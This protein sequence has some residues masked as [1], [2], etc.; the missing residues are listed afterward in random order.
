LL[1]FSKKHEVAMT[2][3][4]VFFLF[5]G[6]SLWGGFAQSPFS[7]EVDSLILR[8]MDQT[9][10]C[11]FD[12]AMAT[13]QRVI[14]R[15]P[16]H[17]VGYFYQAAV[18]QSRMMDYETDLWEGDFY[19]LIDKAIDTGKKQLKRGDDN[20]WTYFYLG[21][22][23]SYK[24]LYQAKA[25]SFISGFISAH[26]GMGYFEKAVEMD[27]T[28]YDAYLGLG[29]Y[30]YWAGRFYKYLKFLPWIK[31]E[32]EKGIGMV[33]LSV[34]KG[35]FSY[36]AGL[37]SLA[38]IEY[39]R[40]R[41]KEALILFKKGLGKYPGSRFFQWGVADSYFQLND[42]SIAALFYQ[43]LLFSILNDSPNN[44]YNEV[45]C[46]FKLALSHFALGYYQE[47]LKECDAILQ[48]GVEEKISIRLEKYRK[49]ARKY[50]KECL[51]R[52]EKKKGQEK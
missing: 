5:L 48:R 10:L 3:R 42:F 30:K 16:D 36:W 37:N 1:K 18:L 29:S 23:Y 46:R 25:G 14:D 28:L 50:R 13:F 24:G 31:D 2:R 20:A 34:D 15:C 44:G 27:S 47:A 9:L 7:F 51:S 35:T 11:E 6:F 12:E 43:E 41:Y 45:V 8:G 52:L 21:S 39:D 4:I 32:R 40:K 33:T 49:A 22:A 17:L 19:R 38:W 26:K